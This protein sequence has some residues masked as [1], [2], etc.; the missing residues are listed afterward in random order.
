MSFNTEK[1]KEEIVTRFLHEDESVNEL[2]ARHGTIDD[3]PAGYYSQD[4]WKRMSKHKCN[5]DDDMGEKVG[6]DTSDMKTSDVFKEYEPFPFPFTCRQFVL[7]KTSSGDDSPDDCVMTV[8]TDKADER[9]L[10]FAF[11]CD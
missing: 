2:C 4:N 9:V 8:I 3:P 5:S 10:A 11:S 1:L 6:Y 7:E